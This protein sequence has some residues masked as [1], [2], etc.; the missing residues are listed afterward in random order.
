MGQQDG[1][2]PESGMSKAE[3]I[4]MDDPY[5]DEVIRKAADGGLG[6]TVPR[7]TPPIG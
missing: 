2:E 7:P 1:R 3:R 5:I 4:A 6:R